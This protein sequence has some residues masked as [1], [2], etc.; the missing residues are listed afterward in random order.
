MLKRL[1]LSCFLLLLIAINSLP[2]IEE[3]QIIEDQ[4][5]LP[6]LTPSLSQRQTLKLR[7]ANGLEAYL[8][9]DPAAVKSAAALFVQVGSFEDPPEYPGIAHFLEHMLF[10][11]TEKYPSES[12]YDRF[13]KEHDGQSNA[14]T[15][16][17]HTLYFFS[18]N[19]NAFEEALDRF[20][21]FFKRPLFNPSGVG[22]ELHAIDQE[23]AKNLNQDEIRAY[24]V[25]KET[26]QPEHPFHQFS[27][28]RSNTLNKVSQRTLKKWYQEH[29][30]AHLMRLVV[31]SPLPLEALKK[32]VVKD[33]KGI[34]TTFRPPYRTSMP[35]F[36]EDIKGHIVYISPIK[37]IR[38]L[39]LTWELPDEFARMQETQPETLVCYVLGHESEGSLLFELRKAD[40]AEDLI[41]SS[42]PIG[43]HHTLFSL[44][45]NLTEKGL[46]DVNTVIERCFEAIHNLKQHEFPS[47]LFDEV[48]T[49]SS[50]RYQY[51]S[52]EDPFKYVM[53]LG[54]WLS[55]EKME[56]FPEHTF[57][58]QRFNPEQVK[59]LINSLNPENVIVS[60]MAQPS[61]T[62]V[63]PDRKEKW[64]GIPYAIRSIP[65]DQ[66]AKWR[67]P[68][69]NP[70]FHLPDPNPFIPQSFTVDQQDTSPSEA[71]IPKPLTLIDAEDAKIYYAK[72]T[73]FQI[74]QTVWFFEIKTPLVTRGNPM[75][76]VL[77]DLYIACLDDVLVDESYNASLA[78]L[79]YELKRT[80]KGIE[81]ALK[82]YSANAE[83][84]FD[85][86]LKRLKDCKPNEQKFAIFKDTLM[87]NYQNFSEESSLKQGL[88]I[89][90]SILY[91]NFATAAEKAQALSQVSYQDFQ[92]YQTHLFDYTYTTGLL[93][94]YIEK[95]QAQRLWDKLRLTLSSKPFPISQQ[96]VT[97]VIVLPKD[98]GPYFV[99]SQVKSQGHAAILGI[100]APSFSFKMR[101]AQQILSQAMNGPFYATLRTQQQTGYIVFNLAEELDRHLFSF[102]IVQSNTHD[103]RDLLARFELFIESFLQEMN[104][105]ELTDEQF[106]RIR[107]SLKTTFTHPPQNLIEMG[108]L[109]KT[110]A[111]D[112]NGD[113]EWVS[114]RIQGFEDLTHEE[115]LEMAAY[116]LGK[117]N[118][119]RLAVLVR[120]A[121]S[122]DKG[123]KYKRL[124]SPREIRELSRYTNIKF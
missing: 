99:E 39:N 91:Q 14:Y 118:R 1:Y 41:C 65:A 13:I 109:L 16:N 15:A 116:F 72:D 95:E 124:K 92:D 82:G 71:V 38:R 31:Y 5:N 76:E 89:Y 36:N 64:M 84:L 42:Y 58:I 115:F 111:F 70:N 100:E 60:L 119:K 112:Y 4:S 51:Q 107:S 34:S 35:L 121:N 78:D 17:D 94:G 53:Q 44:Q 81:L 97:K 90:Y 40:L 98:R 18:I 46:K 113:F 52:R 22:R 23:F 75:Q 106:E 50:M 20:S 2:A 62:G 108:E 69:P 48:K 86:I 21:Y 25:Q 55:R 114:K 74:P 19:N 59:K 105:T 11:G 26:S 32:L 9:S 27:S 8:I 79:E 122:G 103:P 80:N 77:A 49:M 61:L 68:D 93:Y 57:V 33:F 83:V 24:Y 37:N 3:Y 29:Y 123:L 7:L 73:V 12:E 117:E 43:L 110:L 85:S 104:Q 45:I 120:G 96:P 6:I 63:E 102:F 30:S 88:E 54:E 47:Y 66:L 87:R 67:Q 28:G 101:A 10:L 56:T